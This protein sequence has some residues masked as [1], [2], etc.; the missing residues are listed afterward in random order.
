MLAYVTAGLADVH[1]RCH[2]DAA[3]DVMH[4]VDDG[5]CCAFYASSIFPIVTL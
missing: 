3:V 4:V 5:R 1:L 2:G